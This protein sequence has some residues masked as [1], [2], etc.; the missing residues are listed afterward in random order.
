MIRKPIEVVVSVFC[1]VPALVRT[2]G[3]LG[4]SLFPSAGSSAFTLSSPIGACVFEGT[5]R[6]G[7]LSFPRGGLTNL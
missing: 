6:E 2:Q 5:S 4:D 3:T 7:E 1:T